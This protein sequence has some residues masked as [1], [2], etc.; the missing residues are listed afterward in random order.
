MN[1]TKIT[2]GEAGHGFSTG[3]M[4]QIAGSS[5]LRQLK[6]LLVRPRLQ[7]VVA[8]DSTSFTVRERRVTWRE[9]F[10]SLVALIP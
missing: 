9:W 6:R 10:V 7:E 3:D 4:V 1:E 5:R 8:I 2:V